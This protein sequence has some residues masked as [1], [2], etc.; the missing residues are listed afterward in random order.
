MQNQPLE[1]TYEIELKPGERL[2]LPDALVNS[3]GP[4]RWLVTVQPLPP[5][6]AVRDHAP[7]LRGYAPEDEGLYDD[8]AAR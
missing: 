8:C 4:G 2:M 3:V 7:F 1:L 5:A 6:S